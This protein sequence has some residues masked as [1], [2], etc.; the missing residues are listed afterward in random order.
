MIAIVGRRSSPEKAALHV[1]MPSGDHRLAQAVGALL[2]TSEVD[3]NPG[4]LLVQD[5]RDG[6]AIAFGRPDALDRLGEPVEHLPRQL[7]TVAVGRATNDDGLTFDAW[8]RLFASRL[9]DKH[10]LRA[11]DL[12]IT[13]D[14]F[15]TL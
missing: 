7:T 5:A 15:F 1:F 13:D 12:D 9:G 8:R 3:P 10:M 4:N 14:D 11:V 6:L 2:A